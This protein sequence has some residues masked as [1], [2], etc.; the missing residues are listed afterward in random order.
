MRVC[1]IYDCL[2]PW[3]VGGHERWFRHLAERLAGE[4]HEVTFLTRRQWDTGDEPRIAGVRVVDVSRREELY[5]PDG[6][7]RIGEAVRFG[8][9]VT[10]HL[11]RHRGRYDVVHVCSFPYFSLLGARLALAG[12]QTRMFTDWIEVWSAAYWR[13]YAGGPTAVIAR[14]VQWLCVRASPRAFVFSALNARRLREH[15][16]RGSVV[17]LPGLYLGPVAGEA[18]AGA[19]EREPVVLFAGRH[20]A[21][22]GVDAIVP[23][24]ALARRADP[25]LGALV[26]GDGPERPA[27]LAAVAAAGLG[28]AVTAPG[29]VE[30]D[31]LRAAM[32]SAACLLLPS[33]REGYGMVVIEAAAVGTPSVVV[34]APDNAAV[35]LIEDGVNGVVAPSAAAADLAEAI[36][37]VRALGADLRR[38]TAAWFARRAGDLTADRSADEVIAAY[39]DSARS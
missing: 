7:R 36:L 4:G 8:A 5:G 25:E 37:R 3:T 24:L 10:A 28:E 33:R 2:F 26:L 1:L 13:E 27:L 32:S 23:A 35:E 39:A 9:G 18:P 30:A 11:L 20:I 15:G 22:K 6:R 21:E 17:H 16:L 14:L 12:S 31:E 34:A 29:F 19:G 38:S